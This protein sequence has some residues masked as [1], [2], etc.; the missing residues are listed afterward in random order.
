[1]GS[2]A[3]KVAPWA[4]AVAVTLIAAIALWRVD[5][6]ER[7]RAD[8]AVRA[9]VAG[10]LGTLRAELEGALTAPLSLTRGLAAQVIANGGLADRDFERSAAVM[11]GDS[12]NII[13]FT[14]ARGTVIAAI[15]PAAGNRAA[16]GVDY[17]S[18]AH[19]WP[20]I[21][22]AIRT[23]HPVVSG[24]VRLIQG[25]MALVSRTPIFVPVP[26]GEARFFGL[27]SVVLDMPRIWAQVG[28]D[29]ADLPITVAIR[30]VDGQGAGG[31]MVYGDET[32]FARN[33]VEAD[34][35]LPDGSWRLA[36]VPRGGGG[37][38]DVR[39]VR[40][41]GG[42]VVLFVAI[43]AFGGAFHIRVQRRQR[44]ML[45]LLSNSL[46]HRVEES[47]RD[48]TQE[49]AERRLAEAELRVAAG[50]ADSANRA[51]AE[52]LAAM[53][54]ELRTPLTAIIGLSELL[55]EMAAD[56][57]ACA[58]DFD[59]FARNINISGLHLF[60]LINDVLDM[61]AIEAGSLRLCL[62]RMDTAGLVE[63]ADRVVRHA[64]AT[65]NQSLDV[66]LAAAPPRLLVDGR[67]I[68]QV[69]VNLLG[70]AAKF[71]PEGGSIRLRI[72]AEADGGIAMV[73][74]DSGIGMSP[75][76]IAKATTLFGHVDSSLSRRHEGS[77]LGLSLSRRLVGLH[78]GTLEIESTLGEGTVVTVRL[79]ASCVG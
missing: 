5:E 78:G 57:N 77:G 3:E 33:P 43:A 56:E 21:E 69:L 9:E 72:G 11:L 18:Q 74:T 10:R 32:V 76:G 50:A 73:V 14:L 34:V 15:V 4:M 28:L 58:K 54:F 44:K 20:T 68:K 13:N 46:E 71:T 31:A 37:N 75:D 12:R 30:G 49:I 70:N 63:A 25:G 42:V 24:P 19:Q 39:L 27:V 16:I 36:A 45:A 2:L 66:D 23:R 22:R 61:S 1:M 59:V 35:A 48:L 29:R 60:D 79:P 17:R 47:T 6:L 55:M 62:E 41:L 51:K 64:V 53:S 8:A 38:S 26:G 52:F 40:A 7:N 67:R 65:K